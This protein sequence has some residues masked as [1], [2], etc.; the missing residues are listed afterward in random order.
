MK[1]AIII[2]NP[3]MGGAQRVSMNL[4][5]WLQDNGNEVCI[6]GITKT[7]NP[8]YSFDNINYY[9]LPE[10]N[11]IMLLRS[12]VKDYTPEIVLSMGVPL[13]IYTVPACI[14]LNLK[15]V[16]SE[17]NDPSNFAGKVSTKIMA[18]S[19]MRLANAYVFQTKDA[20]KY[21]GGR[22]AKKSVIIPNPLFNE[23][24]MPAQ[25]FSGERRKIIVNV[26][27]LNK[28]KNHTLLIMAFKAIKDK[29]PDY[30]LVIWGEGK[31]R[32]R[33][34]NY[35]DLEGLNDR[36]SLPGNTDAVI[37]KI[38][39]NAL[40]VLSSDFEGMPNALME[41]MA[42]GLPCISTECPCGGPSELILNYENGI[43]VPVGNEEQM[44]KAI[45]YMLDNQDEAEKMGRNAQSIREHYSI[46][47]I[48]N[49]WYS[50]FRT[51]IQ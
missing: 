38:Y 8:S 47:S 32:E 24:K 28:Q 16:I 4:A 25:S 31:E 43:L 36:V 29:Y 7:T 5:Y 27:R 50:Y 26:G 23:S 30:N 37:S 46:D 13:S 3:E 41:A 14:G 2:A 49:R 35:I 19:L 15:H 39:D 48:C 22:I 18:R 11:K 1:I 21:Y 45:S 33:I 9:E 6:I 34:Q 40:F 12:K 51:L 10:G 42:L 44:I 20:Q 17:R